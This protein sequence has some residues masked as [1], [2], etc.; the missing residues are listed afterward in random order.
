MK[1]VG[2]ETLATLPEHPESVPVNAL[3][4]VKGTPM[5]DA[6]PPSGLEM[7]RCVAT[8]RILMPHS[9][10]GL[11]AVVKLLLSQSTTGELEKRGELENSIHEPESL[12]TPKK[13]PDLRAAR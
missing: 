13:R 11:H 12:R 1:R 3:V 5:E 7:V 6:E 9:M 8:A 2:R 10:V 4:A